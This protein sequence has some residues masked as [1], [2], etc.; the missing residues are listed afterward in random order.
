M[1]FDEQAIGPHDYTCSR[2]NWNQRANSR[3]VAGINDYRQV[4]DSLEHWDR[5]HIEGISRSGLEGA[6]SPLAQ[7]DV[8]IATGGN[9]LC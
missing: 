2:Q 3:G 9:E 6:Y 8:R 4:T 1:N 5:R 7:N